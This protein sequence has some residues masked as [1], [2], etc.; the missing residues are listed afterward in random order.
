MVRAT[1]AGAL[2][3]PRRP[4]SVAALLAGVVVVALG[5]VAYAESSSGTATARLPDGTG[6]TRV[7]LVSLVRFSAN[8][9]STAEKTHACTR[10]LPPKEAFTC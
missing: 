1:V 3:D 2:A 5:S 6:T 4:W 9:R 7:S 10:P 8:S